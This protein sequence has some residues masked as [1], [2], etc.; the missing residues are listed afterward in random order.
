MV[1][2]NKTRRQWA[3]TL[4]AAALAATR[5]APAQE[6]LLESSPGEPLAGESIDESLVSPAPVDSLE[7]QPVDA[8]AP[9]MV[10]DDYAAMPYSPGF[11]P[12]S[13]PVN[14]ISGPYLR[15]GVALGI[16]GSV[17][18]SPDAGYTI[19]GG[20]RTP[21]GP[22]FDER[23]FLDA[24]M[25]YLSIFG[26]TTHITDG[27]S[28]SSAGGATPVQ[29]AFLSTLKEIRRLSGQVAVG[30]YWGDLI[31]YRNNDPQ[32]RIATRFGGRLGHVRGDFDDV[33]L[34]SST[35]SPNYGRT[36]TQGGLFMATEAIL[37]QRETRLG[38][39]AWTA[40]AELANDWVKLAGFESG[41]I[42][43]A[44]FMFGFMISR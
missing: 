32:W 19:A 17:L 6:P 14:W 31:D 33:A 24:G 34:I 5:P 10:G 8:P 43:S 44:T 23:L 20:Y 35:L 29:D 16:G 1:R 3:A 21:L 37:L 30:W 42:G 12:S 26:S 13:Q 41:S 39:L 28:G 15:A 27:R 38:S 40:D 22:A 4:L 9:A 2:T 7:P 18:H 11:G 36:D 25:S